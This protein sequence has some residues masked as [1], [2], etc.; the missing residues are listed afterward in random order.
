MIPYRGTLDIQIVFFFIGQRVESFF[1]SEGIGSS[2]FVHFDF[3]HDYVFW[4]VF[5]WF[6]FFLIKS[7]L[8]FYA[9]GIRPLV[10]RKERTIVVATALDLLLTAGC[11]FLFLYAETLRCCNPNN[12]NGN[13]LIPD[14][15]PCSCPAFGSRQYG[16]LG[17]VEPWVSLIALRIFRHWFAK[18][19][20]LAMEKDA[21]ELRNSDFLRQ[22]SQRLNPFDVFA[23][24][25]RPENHTEK[26]A[27]HATHNTHKHH[28]TAG[29]GTAAELWESTIGK[30]PD[31]VAK[32]GE[33]SAEVLRAMLG[34]DPLHEDKPTEESLDAKPENPNNEAVSPRTFSVKKSLS[35]LSKDAQ[36]LI[37]SG[38]LGG[39]V[40]GSRKQGPNQSTST[41]AF[42]TVPI[43]SPKF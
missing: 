17:M 14:V 32:Y 8:V 27:E 13:L 3:A 29:M 12:S 35:C 15:A 20:V 10:S 16:G 37:A 19:I 23:E 41:A 11:L 38:V 7:F 4:V 33:F 26:T 1:L 25:T 30:H 22:P 34:I 28:H 42:S 43:V 6:G 36:K 18:R 2:R 39:D 24:S 5:I 21:H 31:I 40:V 9:V